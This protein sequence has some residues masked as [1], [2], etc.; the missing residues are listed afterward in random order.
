M[1]RFALAGLAVL[2]ALSLQA[3]VAGASTFTVGSTAIPSD[4]PSPQSCNP[5]GIF[6]Q[7][8]GASTAAPSTIAAGGQLTQWQMNTAIDSSGAAGGAVELVALTPEAGFY[9]IDAVDH[10]TMPRPL[11]AGGGAPFTP[12]CPLMVAAGAL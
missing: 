2:A 9:R 10:E 5:A 8:A 6:S 4:S 12:P 3:G 7:S 1:Q 11:P